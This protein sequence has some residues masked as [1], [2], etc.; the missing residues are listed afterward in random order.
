LTFACRVCAP[1]LGPL[2]VPCGLGSPMGVWVPFSA[3]VTR[4]ISGALVLVHDAQH[5]FT[6]GNLQPFG[7]LVELVFDWYQVKQFN[8]SRVDGLLRRA[9]GD[10]AAED[11]FS[12]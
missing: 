1:R 11:G 5:Q 8:N 7:G 4:G 3:V 9:V 10:P 12:A 6:C 2:W